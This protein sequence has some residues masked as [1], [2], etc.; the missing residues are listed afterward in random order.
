MKLISVFHIKYKKD[1][2][3][4]KIKKLIWANPSYDKPWNSSY[5]IIPIIQVISL[6]LQLGHEFKIIQQKIK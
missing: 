5:P 6:N 4:V 2:I 3:K 1:G